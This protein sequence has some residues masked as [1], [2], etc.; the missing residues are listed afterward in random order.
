MNSKSAFSLVE[1]AVVL[2]ILGL[3]TGGI[4][5]GRS[6]IRASELRAVSTELAKH[7]ATLYAFK[8]KYFALPG[9]M[10]NA[11]A[12]WGAADGNDG[13]AGDC[14]AA[15]ITGTL[16]CNGD[17]NGRIEHTRD[18]NYAWQHIANAGL[19]EGVFGRSGSPYVVGTTVPA[20]KLPRTGYLIID[21]NQQWYGKRGPEGNFIRVSKPSNNANALA[22]GVV[23]AEEAWNIDTKMDDG[24]ADGGALYVMRGYPET[25]SSLPA[26]GCVSGARTDTAITFTL[27]DTEKNCGLMYWVD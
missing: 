23:S 22:G 14:D 1:L 19:V 25:S 12:F 21:R 5:A 27:D 16:T 6:L 7:K 26:S 2:V 8:G 17:A 10:P 20:S 13:L 11:T 24:T 15:T 4:L 18:S 9:D 3:L